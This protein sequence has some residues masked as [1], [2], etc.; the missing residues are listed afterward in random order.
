MRIPFT[1]LLAAGLKHAGRTTQ[2]LV[3]FHE[4]P[5]PCHVKHTL[6]EDTNTHTHTLQIINNYFFGYY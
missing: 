5:P 1:F 2:G 4:H 6:Q 3:A